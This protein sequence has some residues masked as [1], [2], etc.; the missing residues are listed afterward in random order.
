VFPEARLVVEYEGSYH[1]EGDQIVLDDARYTRLR[2]A[3][4]TVVRLSAADLRDLDDA[5]ARIR[6]ALRRAEMAISALQG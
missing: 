1:F 4:W 6:A 3:G 2:R 5:V